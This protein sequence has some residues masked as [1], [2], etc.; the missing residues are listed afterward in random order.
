MRSAIFSLDPLLL[1]MIESH[2]PVIYLSSWFTKT[3]GECGLPTGAVPR[4]SRAHT[5]TP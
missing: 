3:I 2:T 5:T 4:P 1:K